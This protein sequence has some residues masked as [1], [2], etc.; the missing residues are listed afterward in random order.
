MIYLDC[1][2]TTKPAP[3]VVL[4]ITEMLTISWANPSSGH[5]MGQR[6]RAAIELA[7]ENMARLLTAKPREIVFTSG[8]SE[9]LDLAIRG[10]VDHSSSRSI[11]LSKIEHR[12]LRQTAQNLHDTQGV[13]VRWLRC[14]R[15]GR[16]CLD[17]LEEL[18]C[19]A[20]DMVSVQW[21][22]SETGVIQPMQQVVELCQRAGVRLHCDATQMAGKMPIDEDIAQGC[23]LLTCS[24]HKFY[25]PKGVGVLRV[26][27]GVSIGPCL[28]GPQELNRRGGTENGLG[29]VGAGKAA[30]LALAWLADPEHRQRQAE[31]RDLLETLLIDGCEYA[32]RITPDSPRV[33]NTS[34]MGFSG[35]ASEAIL[36][37]LSERGVCA[38]AG[39]ACASG[40]LEPSETILA[41]G[42]EEKLARGVLRLSL[43]RETTRQEVQEAAATLI[44]VAARVGSSSAQLI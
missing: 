8:G 22:N 2:A 39:T 11:V 4:A 18:L 13:E 5:R 6:A 36:I 14:N 7:R 10:S 23:D 29:I 27:Q 24:P 1:N 43:G 31:I 28:L 17:H 30:E 9:S 35:L 21:V 34:C 41:M 33:W 12:A 20:P 16:I 44:E 42:V 15:D 19:P 38:S 3:E 37:G 25:G 40:S 32:M 26:R